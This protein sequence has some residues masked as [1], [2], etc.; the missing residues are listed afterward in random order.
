MNRL[1]YAL[2]AII[3]VLTITVVIMGASIADAD[4]QNEANLE[5]IADQYDGIADQLEAS[6]DRRE[7]TA[8]NYETAAEEFEY[9]AGTTFSDTQYW[10][11]RANQYYELAEDER[12]SAAD[13][14]ERADELRDRAD[15]IRNLREES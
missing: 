13:L 8:D 6:A 2:L 4:E 5:A 3:G 14:R 12:A 7:A 15:E 1:N 9:V 11:Q 10:N